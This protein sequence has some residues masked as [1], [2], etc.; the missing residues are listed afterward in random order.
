LKDVEVQAVMRARLD[1]E[2]V[3]AGE[4]LR[5]LKR[6]GLVDPR[7]FFDEHNHLRPVSHWTPEMAA[8]VTSFEVIKKNA[9][10]G[11]GHVDV[12]HKIRLSP[13]IQALEILCKRLGLLTPAPD[14]SGKEVPTFIFPP[15][16]EISIR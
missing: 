5:E 13:K 9:A 10:A 4:V 7:A 2:K 1:E 16:T 3:V 8:A 15:G 11:D 14:E 12:V 6:I